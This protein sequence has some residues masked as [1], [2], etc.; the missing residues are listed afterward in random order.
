M[1]Q[2]VDGYMRVWGW[3]PTDLSRFNRKRNEVVDAI[4]HVIDEYGEIVR[5]REFKS[6]RDESAITDHEIFLKSLLE[7]DNSAN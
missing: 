7:D 6:P 4:Y 5:W 3:I 1:S 2:A